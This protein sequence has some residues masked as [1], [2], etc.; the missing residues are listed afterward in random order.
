[1]MR[2]KK[3]KNLSGDPTSKTRVCTN[4]AREVGWGMI[5]GQETRAK[6]RGHSGG[7]EVTEEDPVERLAN[8]RASTLSALCTKG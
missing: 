5:H 8:A 3:E 2:R 7:E 4:A 1:M 6:G